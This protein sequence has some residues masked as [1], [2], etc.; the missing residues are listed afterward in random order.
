M[1]RDRKEEEHQE[2]QQQQEQQHYQQSE[3]RHCDHQTPKNGGKYGDKA[4]WTKPSKKGRERQGKKEQK[5]PGTGVEKMSAKTFT[6]SLENRQ[7]HAH[8][9]A[10]TSGRHGAA[11]SKG[12]GEQHM[13]TAATPR[14]TAHQPEKKKK[15][16]KRG[17]GT[18]TAT[19]TRR[20]RDKR[21]QK[22]RSINA[23]RSATSG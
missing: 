10:D 16:C 9:T 12:G 21:E 22:Q 18:N 20:Q 23:M 6:K 4:P 1:Q 13:K 8:P 5:I 14:A 19:A 3:K 7:I 2:Q 11:P 15:K 17:K